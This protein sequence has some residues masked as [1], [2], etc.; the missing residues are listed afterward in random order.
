MDLPRGAMGLSAV[1]IVAFP[2]H[3]HLLFLC[4]FYFCSHLALEERVDCFTEC[5]VDVIGI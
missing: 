4:L 5:H 2:D 1:V 3:T